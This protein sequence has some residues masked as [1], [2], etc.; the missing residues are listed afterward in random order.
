MTSPQRKLMAFVAT[1]DGERVKP[2]YRDVLGLPLLED[3]P[4]ALVFDAYGVT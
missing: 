1:N 3:S 2:F 4:F